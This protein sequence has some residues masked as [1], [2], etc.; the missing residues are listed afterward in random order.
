[1]PELRAVS[2]AGKVDAMSSIVDFQFSKK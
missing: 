2:I 1:M